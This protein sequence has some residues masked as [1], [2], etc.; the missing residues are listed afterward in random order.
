[1]KLLSK[2]PFFLSETFALSSFP[3]HK[4]WCTLQQKQSRVSLQTK[5]CRVTSTAVS[6]TYINSVLDKSC[7]L[8]H[9]SCLLEHANHNNVGDHVADIRFQ[10]SFLMHFWEY[11]IIAWLHCINKVS[12]ALLFF[13]ASQSLQLHNSLCVGTRW[14]V[15]LFNM[16]Y[17]WKINCVLSAFNYCVLKNEIING[18]MVTIN[19]RCPGVKLRILSQN[20]QETFQKYTK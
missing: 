16:K 14:I 15:F 12:C 17:L 4:T 20:K 6:Q 8:F 7:S 11:S 18:I 3:G 9:V 1:M 13:T 10:N 5:Y 19:N 2:F